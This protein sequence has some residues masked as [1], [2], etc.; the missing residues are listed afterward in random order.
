M[1]AQ[2][3]YARI[4]GAVMN[5]HLVLLIAVFSTGIYFAESPSALADPG[6]KQQAA[7][8]AEADKEIAKLNSAVRSERATAARLRKNRKL[9]S[10]RPALESICRRVSRRAQAAKGKG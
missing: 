8:K 10:Y 9:R 5:T 1:N 7:M 4:C 2:L 6:S 3:T